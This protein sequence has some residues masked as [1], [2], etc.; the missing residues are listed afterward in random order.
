MTSR[1][2]L[3]IDA[4]I[5]ASSS[6]RGYADHP[7]NDRGGEIIREIIVAVVC[8]EGSQVPCAPCPALRPSGSTGSS[9]VL[10]RG[11]T[12]LLACRLLWRSRCSTPVA[13]WSHR[14]PPRCS[15]AASMP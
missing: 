6:E 11:S 3:D 1:A 12:G 15:K 4:V 14:L 8:E 10:R 7:H 13:A 9:T 5:G 2:I